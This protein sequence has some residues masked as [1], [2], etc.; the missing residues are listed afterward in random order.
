MVMMR[1]LLVY[2]NLIKPIL[3][4]M[5]ILAC[6]A[7]HFQKLITTLYYANGNHKLF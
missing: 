5:P 3:V 7:L 4:F 2:F 6:P 1:F